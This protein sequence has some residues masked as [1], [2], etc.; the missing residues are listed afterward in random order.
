METKTKINTISQADLDGFLETALA[1]YKL[2]R[3]RW[4]ILDDLIIFADHKWEFHGKYEP[5]PDVL[6]QE[7][8]C[9]RGGNR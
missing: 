6:C 7:E 1:R 3:Y 5:Q 8:L 4:M 9:C 2:K